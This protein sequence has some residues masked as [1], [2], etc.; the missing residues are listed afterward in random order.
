LPQLATLLLAPL[1]FAA[2]LVALT[3]SSRFLRAQRRVS[4]NCAFPE[5]EVEARICD[6]QQAKEGAVALSQVMS[7]FLAKT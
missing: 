1:G 5:E 7:A 2:A 3:L 6:P 4:T